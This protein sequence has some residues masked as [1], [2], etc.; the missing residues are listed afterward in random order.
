M[1]LV[2]VDV[3]GTFTDVV[4]YDESEKELKVL[5]VPTQKDSED[6][7]V[8][9]GINSIEMNRKRIRRITHGTT[10][11]TNTLLERKGSST[12]IVTT[13]GFKDLIEI[14]RTQRL[15]P[16]SLF[17]AKF[18]RPSPL[19]SR[20]LRF[21]LNERI[22]HDGT[23]KTR[24]NRKDIRKLSA[25]LK[26]SDV[27]AVAICFLHSYVENKNEEIAAEFLR[28]LN[29]D[30]YISTSN[31]VVAEFREFERF[32]TT[33]INSYIGPRIKS[34]ISDLGE[35]LNKEHINAPLFVMASNG[36]MLDLEGAIVNPTQTILSGPAGGIVGAVSLS[37][38]VGYK[39]LITYD[40]GG[41]SS[42]VCLIRNNEPSISIDNNFSSM[43]LKIPQLQINTVGAGG[44]SI[45]YCDEDNRLHVGPESSGSTPGPACYSKG[46]KS[47]TVTDA[48]LVLS[49]IG[50]NSLLGGDFILNSKKAFQV[51]EKLRKKLNVKNVY[52]M[53]NGIVQVAVARMVSSIREI[54]IEKGFD[55]RE[56][57]LV[58]Y[59]GAGPLHAA[60][61]AD[62]LSIDSVLIPKFPGN[63]SAV[64]LLMADL[65]HDV[66]QT[67][68]LDLEKSS[69]EQIFKSFENIE[70]RTL[71]QIKVRDFGLVSTF[72]SLDL[73][74]KNQAFELNISVEKKR[75][76]IKKIK[77][78]F[79]RK[80]LER[81]GHNHLEHKIQ[82]VN[83]RLRFISKTN[84]PVWA[85]MKDQGSSLQKAIKE[86]RDV[87]F[88]KIEKKCCVYDRDLLRTDMQ[89]KGPCI[90]EEYGSTTIVPPSWKFK[91]DKLGNLLLLK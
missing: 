86:K 49:R 6:V 61:I 9:H 7:G 8:L 75:M 66:V 84:K 50:A 46:G 28:F 12:A 14:G 89:V 91:K 37:K 25:T 60:L 26:K 30:L 23:V 47:P 88:D 43:P 78:N 3:G 79:H 53:A 55:P 59:G 21:E 19:V 82:L 70:K 16:R 77:E 5:K 58:A 80:Y 67:N 56:H 31:R 62:E 1:F 69:K 71:N 68:I 34:Y 83:F 22:L 64:G 41:T 52:V 65:T 45:A 20:E 74:Y 36:G 11:G 42:D 32:S 38:K 90:V 76:S 4:L 73:R 17:D 24:V 51:V 54:S 81:Y 63:F 33:A 72:W 10:V 39:N 44:G 85:N 2:G 27:E 18:V 57:V 13:K 40:M 35:K 48:N 15:V 29:P 87:Y